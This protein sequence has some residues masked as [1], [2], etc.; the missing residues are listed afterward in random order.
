[1]IS[2]VLTKYTLF[3]LR[4]LK[5]EARHHGSIAAYQ[6]YL[7]SKQKYWS[8]TRSRFIDNG[9][10][11]QPSENPAH[12]LDTFFPRLALLIV[13]DDMA[14]DRAGLQVHPCSGQLFKPIALVTL[15]NSLE[16]RVNY[17]ARPPSHPPSVVG[18]GACNTRRV[19]LSEVKSQGD[20]CIH[21]TGMGI[22]Q[23]GSSCLAHLPRRYHDVFDSQFR[24]SLSGTSERQHGDAAATLRA[25]FLL[26]FFR[27]THPGGVEWVKLHMSCPPSALELVVHA[28][29][30]G[31]AERYRVLPTDATT[32]ALAC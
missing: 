11:L 15:L 13:M 9:S 18:P 27:C 8:F 12:N 16:M 7:C 21:S 19:V 30:A 25:I 31:V 3:D 26:L 24:L 29:S 20:G 32:P 4:F 22:T 1:M 2:N 17:D 28:V 23:G 10:L 14:V 5:I 6:Q